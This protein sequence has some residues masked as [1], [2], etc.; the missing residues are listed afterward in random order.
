[1]ATQVLHDAY[2]VLGVDPASDD[3]SIA[4]AYRR[5]ARRYHPDIAGEGA[6]VRMMKINAAWD[7]LRD[8]SRRAEY[9]EEL[10]EIDPARAAAARRRARP[11]PKAQDETPAG[12]AAASYASYQ[13]FDKPI[14][15]DGTGSAGRPPGRPSGSILPFGRFKDWSLGEIARIDAGY[16]IWLE[17]RPDGRPYLKEIDHLLRQMGIRGAAEP[18]KDRKSRFGR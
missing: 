17:E 10:R 5:L 3:A 15:R 1:M 4:A 16:L 14:S 13:P 2:A 18:T 11:R 7:R 12:P 9:D 6:T 8:A